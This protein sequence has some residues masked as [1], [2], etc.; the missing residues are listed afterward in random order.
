MET[1]AQGESTMENMA[2]F[3]KS[4]KRLEVGQQVKGTVVKVDADAVLVDVGYKSEGIIPPN[5]VS[6]KPVKHLSEAV[7]EGDEIEVIVL[8]QENREGHPIL[9][10]KRA[11]AE[12]SWKNMVESFKNNTVLSGTCTEKVKG[13]LIL[14]IMGV[15][16]FLPGSH[17]DIMPVRDLNSLLGESMQVKVIQVD[18]DKRNIV[19][20]RRKY[21][22]EEQARKRT[23]LWDNIYEG[24]MLT[25]RVVRL[26]NFGAFVDLG[27]VDGLIHISELS[28]KRVKNPQEVINAGDRVEVVVIN[29]D[30]E[31]K[32][33]ALSLKQTKPDPWLLV[34]D[35]FKAGQ[36]IEGVI[37]R[38]AKNYVFVEVD[39][40]IEGLVP[41]SELAIERVSRPEDVVQK[42][43]KIKV[44]IVDIKPLEKRMLLSASQIEADVL[45][46]EY[47]PFI[48]EEKTGSFTVGDLLKDKLKNLNEKNEEEKTEGR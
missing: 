44:K 29:I 13:G 43:Q 37:T 9:S 35:K 36:A 8:K 28:Y 21:L 25:G 11:D 4:L 17:A 15:R 2:D 38:I 46:E 7:S 45:K 41:L 30:K 42:G 48:A 19:V 26:A 20:S 27:G 23:E 22:E 10:K 1:I 40:G 47:K 24:A 18:E 31:K 39:E 16:A 12:L 33:I 34:E 6:L 3:E 14:N 32:K 5:E